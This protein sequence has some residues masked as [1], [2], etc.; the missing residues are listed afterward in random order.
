LNDAKQEVLLKTDGSGDVRFDWQLSTKSGKQAIAASVP[1]VD[2]PDTRLIH[3][4][5][6]R[7]GVP[8][9]L[10]QF[11]NNQGGAAG[12]MLPKP[13][14]VQVLDEFENPIPEWPVLFV[15][16]LGGGAFENGKSE[17]KVRTNAN[18]EGIATL[19]VGGDPGFN[20]VKAAVEGVVKE[21]KFQAMSMA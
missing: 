12:E 8:R 14:K 17:I 2:A 5:V 7:P 18:G 19:R 3:A 4:I 20:T 13:L 9:K 1:G 6:T 10:K 16:E 15:I 21:L 11:G